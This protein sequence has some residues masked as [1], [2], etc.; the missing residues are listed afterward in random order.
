MEQRRRAEA[1]QLRYSKFSPLL[2]ATDG[3][4]SVVS[5]W[6]VVHFLSGVVGGLVLNFVSVFESELG[7][8]TLGLFLLSILWEVFENTNS[9]HGILSWLWPQLQWVEHWANACMDV[10]VLCCGYGIVYGAKQQQHATLV[11]S[12]ASTVLIF[13]VGPFLFRPRPSKKSSAP[14]IYAG[15]SLDDVALAM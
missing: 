15:K 9:Y 8:W 5:S 12:T 3:L 6:S 10:V 2:V 4:E 13:A 1:H 7:W 11:V 14:I